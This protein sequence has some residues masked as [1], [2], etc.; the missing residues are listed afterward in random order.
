MSELVRQRVPDRRTGDRKRPTVICVETT[1]RYN[2][3]VTVCRTQTKPRSGKAWFLGGAVAHLPS[4]V[5]GSA[6]STLWVLGESTAA[7]SFIVHF[8]FFR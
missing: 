4:M 8:E 6:V 7:K 5:L 1:A 3:L 2:E